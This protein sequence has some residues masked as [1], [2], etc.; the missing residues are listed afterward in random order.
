MFD[1]FNNDAQGKRDEFITPHLNF[2]YIDSAWMSFDHAYCRYDATYHDTLSVLVSTDCGAT[3]TEVFNKGYTDLATAPDNTGYFVPAATEWTTNMIDLSAFVNQQDVEI[4]FQNR[5][6]YGNNLYIDNIN[7][8]AVTSQKPVTDFVAYNDLICEGNAVNFQ[9]KSGA[10]P[11]AWQW[12]FT[13][14]SPSL[15]TVQNPVVVYNTAGVYDV[16]CIA[17]NSFGSDSLTFTQYI[18]VV[19][20]SLNSIIGVSG[21]QLYSTN[22][23]LGY[24]WFL[25]GIP[26]QSA[27]N[28]T[29]EVMMS[30]IYTLQITD[31]NGCTSNSLPVNMNTSVSELNSGHEFSVYPNPFTEQLNIQL[32]S[33]YNSMI[34]IRMFDVIG[35][36]CYN[37]QQLVQ[38]GLNN[39]V[40]DSDLIP[41]IYF[42]EIKSGLKRLCLK[43]IKV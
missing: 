32:N 39:I 31:S 41:G 7:I 6:H 42:V 38:A 4:I 36:Q 19:S 2:V 33:K 5:G 37:A 14:G 3:F 29:L 17:S 27:T 20:P 23:A 9:D 24:Q 18:N 28:D 11:T 13:G 1:N 30:G 10:M 12:T 15:S 26:L 43:V 34:D 35:K 21:N 22:A 25:N 16:T 8:N 40:I